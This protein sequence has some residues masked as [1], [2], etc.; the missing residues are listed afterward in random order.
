MPE[1]FMKLDEEKRMRI[2]NAAMREFARRGYKDAKTDNIVREAGISKGL[3]F[4]YF[5]TKKK[6]YLFL[7]D[8]TLDFMESEFLPQVSRDKDIFE[9]LLQNALLKVK[10]YSKYADLINFYTSAHFKGIEEVKEE[11]EARRQ[12]FNR[13]AYAAAYEGLDLS[14][15]RDDVDPEVAMEIISWT[16]EGFGSKILAQYRDAP[17]ENIDFARFTKEFN[18]YT[19]VLKRSLYKQGVEVEKFR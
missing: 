9:R 11:V 3:L 7:L 10:Q 16:V 8:Y 17:V 18:K 19:K 1:K 15:F 2:I 4:H 14:K 5:G 6:L 12:A 13:K